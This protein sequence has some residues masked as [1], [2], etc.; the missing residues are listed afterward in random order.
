MPFLSDFINQAPTYRRG[1]LSNLRGF[2]QDTQSKQ[3]VGQGLLDAANRGL[4]AQTLGAPVD[5]ANSL[6]NLLY[7]GAGYAGNKLGLL[8]ADQ[9]PQIPDPRTVVGSSE[10]WGNKLQQGG[11]V[12]ENRNPTAETLA[13]LLAPAAYKGA[14]K[15]GQG[16]FKT[17]QNMLANAAKPST[18]NAATNGQ[19]GAVVWHGSPHKFDKFDSS[20]IGT[21]EGAQS[22]GDGSYFAESP[23][24]AW[25]YAKKL[26]AAPGGIGSKASD[27][28]KGNNYNKNS[29]AKILLSELRDAR[30]N[31]PEE[32]WINTFGDPVKNLQ[33]ELGSLRSG[34]NMYKVDLPDE[35]I[36]K[37]LDWDK[38]LSKQPHVVEA[39][40]T[41]YRELPEL[42]PSVGNVLASPNVFDGQHLYQALVNHKS[43]QV[44]SQT[45]RALGIPGIRY[46]DGASRGTGNGTSNFVVFPGNEDMLS[47][48]ERNGRPVK[49]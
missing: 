44:A 7:A 28:V 1:L 22:Y 40:N 16:L 42:Y 6:T 43:P 5:I 45:L 33:E 23:D 10:W 24:V 15:V 47:M 13:G 48:L 35:H 37:M 30:K 46:L 39:A 12:S 19:G 38:P 36:A 25:S 9:M 18:F 8:N 17:E 3:Q 31:P 41:L 32:W 14:T 26:S 21:G 20:K 27:L 49:P 4:V 11:F 34:F 29:A 2:A